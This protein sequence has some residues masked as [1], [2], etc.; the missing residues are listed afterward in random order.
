MPSSAQDAERFW[1]KVTA[2]GPCWEW[3]KGLNANGYG[4]FHA[5][6]RT[7]AAH[8]HAW[9]ILVGPIPEGLV[10]DHLCRNRACVNP[11]HLEPVSHVENVM[12]GYGAMARHARMDTCKRGHEF[13]PENTYHYRTSRFCRACRKIREQKASTA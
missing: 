4:T 13:T 11:D 5:Q 9:E 2:S 1:R 7:H 3:S 12:R 10:L 8:R 6:R